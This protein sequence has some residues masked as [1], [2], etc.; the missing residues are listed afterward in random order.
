[1]TCLQDKTETKH[2]VVKTGQ[3]W[4]VPETTHPLPAPRKQQQFGRNVGLVFP[5]LCL[6]QENLEIWIFLC[7]ISWI[8][9][10]GD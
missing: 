10:A 7:E 3:A 2:G 1:M 9:N 6:F 8:L 4:W 5:D